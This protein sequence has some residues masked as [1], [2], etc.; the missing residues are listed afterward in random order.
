MPA[1]VASLLGS[2]GKMTLRRALGPAIEHARELSSERATVLELLARK[3]PTAFWDDAVTGELLHFVGRT[4]G[5]TL[6]REDLKAVRPDLTRCEAGRRSPQTPIRVP[7]LGSKD[8]DGSFVQVVAAAD[9]KGLVIV[10]CYESG[11]DRGVEL[12]GLGL[13]APAYAEPVMRGKTRL[14]PGTPLPSAGPMA[15]RMTQ[16]RVDVALGVAQAKDAERRVADALDPDD[17]GDLALRLAQSA[18]DKGTFVAVASG[19]NTSRVLA[20]A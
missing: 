5:G 9:S 2:L 8:L 4:S 14:R 6:T 19:R 15:L 13:L 11:D 7:W 12:P 20:S 3:G 16:S 18:S 17:L 1:A 10:G